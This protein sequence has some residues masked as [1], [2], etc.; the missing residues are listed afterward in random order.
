MESLDSNPFIYI[1]WV[2]IT[3]GIW[4]LCELYTWYLNFNFD[5]KW[6]LNFSFLSQM[7]PELF[8]FILNGTWN[9]FFSNFFFGTER[10]KQ[11]K[12][13]KFFLTVGWVF[14]NFLTVDLMIGTICDKI[15]KFRYHLWSKVKFRY[16][17]YNWGKVQVPF[18]IKTL[19]ILIF[20]LLY[21]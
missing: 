11:K 1:F 19:I 10:E 3:N 21:F 16:H 18:V 15:E 14:L 6:Y 4:T 9:F 17:V 7:V 13:L 5:H 20:W 12:N 8:V 2:F